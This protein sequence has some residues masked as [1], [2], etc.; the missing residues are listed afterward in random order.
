MTF[1]NVS[2]REILARLPELCLST[3]SA[4]HSTGE[5]ESATLSAMG[6]AIDHVAGTIRLSCGWYTSQDEIDRVA[7]LLIDA[8][9]NL[10]TM[11][12]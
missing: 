12:A 6:K 10:S 7:E 11:N 4:C 9:E 5:V 8:W 2:A 3:G 1:P